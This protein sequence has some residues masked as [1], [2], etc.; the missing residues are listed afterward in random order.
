MIHFARVFKK[1]YLQIIQKHEQKL[2]Y[3]IRKEKSAYSYLI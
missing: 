3:M 1:T 2:N